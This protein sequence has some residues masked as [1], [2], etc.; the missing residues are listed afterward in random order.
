MDG[1]GRGWAGPGAKT[2]PANREEQEQYVAL[3]RRLEAEEAEKR[4][5]ENRERV[6]RGEKP[7]KW[8]PTKS[9][10]GFEAD[11]EIFL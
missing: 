5:A 1:Y 9:P 2:S 4:E 7:C 11:W 10:F 6:A 8:P 3:K